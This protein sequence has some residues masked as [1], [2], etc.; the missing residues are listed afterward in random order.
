MNQRPTVEQILRVVGVYGLT[1]IAYAVAVI[2]ESIAGG[3]IT[4]ALADGRRE[5]KI[6]HLRDHIIICGYGRA[7]R[8]V[9]EEFRAAG[10][11]YVVLDFNFAVGG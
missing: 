10:V 9:A 3:V 2:V 1:I 5:R 6:E 7:G 4:G 8:R 11:G